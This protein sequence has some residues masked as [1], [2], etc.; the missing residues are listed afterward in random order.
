MSV[1]HDPTPVFWL[2]YCADNPPDG[3]WDQAFLARVLD[4]DESGPPG[5]CYER[6]DEMPSWGVIVFPAGHY[7]EHG[8][9]DDVAQ[10]LAGDLAELDQRRRTV[11]IATSD[12]CQSFPWHTIDP[13]PDHVT[14]WVMLPKPGHRY[15]PRTRFIVE[16]SPR[17]ASDIAA[18]APA[19]GRRDI[20]VIL[21]AQGGHERR[22]M[23]FKAAARLDPKLNAMVKRTEGFTLGFTQD[24]Y[25]HRMARAKVAFAP[26][27]VRSPS[28]FRVYEAIEAGCVPIVDALPPGGTIDDDRFWSMV[29]LESAF[30]L[31]HIWRDAPAMVAG[32]MYR[33]HEAAA[34]TSARWQRWKRDYARRL[35]RDLGRR[36]EPIFADEA[37]TVIIPTS[38]TPSNPSVDGI[39]AT[40]ESVRSY[41][42]DAEIV[43]TCDGVRDEQLDRAGAYHEFLHR[44]T[45]WTST[46][47]NIMPIIHHQHRHQ[48]GML[49]DALDP[50]VVDTDFVLYVEADCPLEGDLDFDALLRVIIDGDL[51]LLRLFHEPCIQQGSEHLFFD[52]ITTPSGRYVQTAQWSQRPHLAD[53]VWYRDLMQRYFAPEARTFIEDVMHGVVQHDVFATRKPVASG[54]IEWGMGV[55]APSGSWKRSGHSDGRGGDPKFP[56]LIQY[57]GGQ[58]PAGGP[59]EGWV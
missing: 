15:P 3:R 45:M 24:E 42:P 13:W 10:R 52:L 8:E 7:A 41:L 39:V 57:P 40:V 54:V 19:D 44:L 34:N 38:P 55:Y 9:V 25:L 14:L 11:L 43:I 18:L 51:N 21:I 29:G 27:G 32:L 37:I 5:V 31:T 33:H 23:A 6:V 58:R 1:L 47:R 50:L 17:P 36:G 22:D 48:S 49:I 35:D 2:S 4:R 53:T 20:D 16:G 30:P 12:E 26:A 28:S 46:R 59:P 56:M